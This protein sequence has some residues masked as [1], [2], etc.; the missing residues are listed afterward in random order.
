VQTFYACELHKQIKFGKKGV[1]VMFSPYFLWIFE[2]SQ[3]IRKILFL[4][5]FLSCPQKKT[6]IAVR[7]VLYVIHK[8][9]TIEDDLVIK[10]LLEEKVLLV[11]PSD[12]ADFYDQDQENV[13]TNLAK[14]YTQFLDLSFINSNKLIP[15]FDKIDVVRFKGYLI[16]INHNFISEIIKCSR[17]SIEVDTSNFGKL[18]SVYSQTL[19][20]Q[21][22]NS[23]DN[24]TVMSVDFIR[25]V[26]LLEG[27][28][29][30]NTYNLSKKCVADPLKKINKI[31]NTNYDFEKMKIDSGDIMW[32][33]AQEE[34]LNEMKKLNW[35]V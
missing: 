14:S 2:I 25:S 3:V 19:F 4:N 16:H 12:F 23:T 35:Q 22:I 33:I 30:N 31:F 15:C 27:L 7:F 9:S 24:A 20:A 17:K 18:D 6:P 26:F 10:N 28:Y 34:K 1:T 29:S 21:L 32:V 11:K 8:I 13:R 5:S